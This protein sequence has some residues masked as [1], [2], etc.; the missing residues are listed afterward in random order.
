MNLPEPSRREF[1]RH[2]AL[3]ATLVAVPTALP[4]ATTD[5]KNSLSPPANLLASGYLTFGPSEAAFV[6]AMVNLMCPADEFTPCGVDCGLAVF[7]DR[8][9]A[10]AFGRG[11]RLYL[12]GPWRQGRPEDGYQLPLTPEQFFKTGLKAADHACHQQHGQHFADIAAPLADVFLLAIAEGK[13]L[14][15]R[16]SLADWFNDLVYPAGLLCGSDLRGQSRQGILEAVG[17]SRTTGR[18]WPQHG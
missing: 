8:Q 14:D 15:A 10:G 3:A 13:I 18:Q 16:L 4:G 9:L 2:A 1:L 6:E 5:E 12:R 7:M 17:L 11:E